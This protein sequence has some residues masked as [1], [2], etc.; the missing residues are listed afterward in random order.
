M[1]CTFM[2]KLL[3]KSNREEHTNRAAFEEIVRPDLLSD[4]AF[5]AF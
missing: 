3:F 1:F 2:Q 4:N 5:M